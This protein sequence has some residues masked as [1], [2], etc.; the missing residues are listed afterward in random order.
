MPDD[1]DIFDETADLNP[2]REVD[3]PEDEIKKGKSLSDAES[4]TANLTDLQATLKYLIP[5][6][7]DGEINKLAQG[8]MVAR[9]FPDTY[10]DRMFLSVE[11]LVEHH[12]VNKPEDPIDVM[13]IINL[14]DSI[15]SIGLDGKGR[16][17]V[18]EVMGKA[19]MTEELENL[20]KQGLGI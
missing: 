13:M 14:V 11:S 5:K 3:L 12:E 16:V 15:F 6:F 1:R 10:L 8:V 9:V 2:E 18:I 19:S 17:D 20:N 7:S 4:E